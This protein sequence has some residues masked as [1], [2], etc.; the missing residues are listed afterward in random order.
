MR[1]FE[2]R[3]YEKMLFMGNELCT[4]KIYELQLRFQKA[5]EALGGIQQPCNCFH[6]CDCKS[7]YKFYKEQIETIVKD[8]AM[9]LTG[10]EWEPK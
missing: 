1:H 10:Q 9:A 4:G 6:H 8:I 3:E 2:D 5:F 7:E